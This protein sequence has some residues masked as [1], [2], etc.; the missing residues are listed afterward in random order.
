MSIDTAQAQ[1][2]ASYSGVLSSLVCICISKRERRARAIHSDALIGDLG[3]EVSNE[4]L[5]E[6]I[7]AR[8]R[9]QPQQKL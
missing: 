1:A 9:A 3:L 7:F 8:I 2:Q 4:S 6:S 5:V